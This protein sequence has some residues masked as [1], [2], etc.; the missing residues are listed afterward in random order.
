MTAP[1]TFFYLYIC[2]AN[3]VPFLYQSAGDLKEK[4]GG[5]DMNKMRKKLHRMKHLVNAMYM[6]LR[7]VSLECI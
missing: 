4:L 6:K 1:V 5:E 7:R 3:I 2:L